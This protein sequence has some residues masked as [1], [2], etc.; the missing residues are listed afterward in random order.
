M[1]QSIIDRRELGELSGDSHTVT[2]GDQVPTNPPRKLVRTRHRALHVPAT[3]L[4]ELAQ[5]DEQSMHGGIEVCR[6]FGNPLPQLIEL[7]VHVHSH[8]TQP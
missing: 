3:A 6:L 5:I 8:I 7:T 2:R 1:S 4:V